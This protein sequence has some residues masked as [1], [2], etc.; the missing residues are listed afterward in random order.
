MTDRGEK[1]IMAV[2]IKEAK[3]QKSCLILP[4]KTSTERSAIATNIATTKRRSAPTFFFSFFVANIT[5]IVTNTNS[6]TVPIPSI[7][8]I[9]M[10][11]GDT[12]GKPYLLY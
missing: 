7:V 5:N 3:P 6:I 12:K 1:Y 11:L 9:S 2:E 10:L 4:W 8:V